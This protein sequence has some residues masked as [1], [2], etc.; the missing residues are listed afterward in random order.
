MTD[1]LPNVTLAPL[2][3]Q[4]L[5]VLACIQKWAWSTYGMTP[6]YVFPGAPGW[7]EIVNKYWEQKRG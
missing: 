6:D 2:S 7:K 3:D 1:L 4:E 5:T